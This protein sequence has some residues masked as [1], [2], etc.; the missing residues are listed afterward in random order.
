MRFEEVGVDDAGLRAAL[1]VQPG[2]HRGR[3][4]GVCV[5]GVQGRSAGN[6]G[7]GC[8]WC[9]RV[10]VI[11]AADMAVRTVG[12]Q[13]CMRQPAL[14][15]KGSTRLKSA[16]YAGAVTPAGRQVPVRKT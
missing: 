11:T 15:V 10:A 14:V 1:V 12:K 6:G 4:P 3:Q 2:R 5:E 9:S 13:R 8:G 16:G 7:W